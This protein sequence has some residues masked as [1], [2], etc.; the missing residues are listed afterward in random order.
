MAQTLATAE[1]LLGDAT[2]IAALRRSIRRSDRDAAAAPGTRTDQTAPMF[3]DDDAGAGAPGSGRA[4]RAAAILPALAHAITDAA[5]PQARTF[6]TRFQQVTGALVAKAHEDCAAF[7][8]NPYLAANE[9]GADPDAPTIAADE[10]DAWLAARPP[11]SLTLTS[12]HDTK[13][14]GDA[15][16]RL[17]AMS[18]LPDAFA[19]LDASLRA[20]PGAH[21]VSRNRRWYLAQS[22]LAIWDDGDPT[23]ADRLADHMTKALREARQI[24][25]WA[26]PDEDAEATV[27]DLARALVA[28]WREAPP[29]GLGAL[30]ARGT[31]L[32]L[33]QTALALAL[34]GVPDIYGA[35]FGIDLALT[36]P[37]NRKPV[38]LAAMEA[39][40]DGPGASGRKARLARALLRLR[41]AEPA[42][43]AQAPCRIARDAA[44]GLT[45]VRE[46][47]AHRLRVRCDPGGV[48]P[49]PGSVW[50]QGWDADA[51]CVAVDWT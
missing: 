30:V 27:T 5:S 24:T 1:R 39:L 10:L 51:A 21:G 9:V 40:A 43:F 50:P 44:H 20:L 3:G 22:A 36:D 18:H 47:P 33:A 42:F 19:D 49:A 14:S 16:M 17:V 35:G 48:T 6:R 38:A 41:R 13:R 4:E 8:W 31:D 26:H 45:L 46:T 37:D 2:A 29:A 15:R 11:M 34:P 7:R 23:L 25:I 32:A 28:A 12:S